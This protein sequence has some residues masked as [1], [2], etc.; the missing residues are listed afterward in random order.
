MNILI[1]CKLYMA[2]ILIINNINNLDLSKVM[3]I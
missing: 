1:I 2:N 3:V